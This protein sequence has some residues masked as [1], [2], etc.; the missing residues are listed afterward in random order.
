MPIEKHTKR[1]Y[2]KFGAVYQKGRETP[3]GLPYN[4]FYEVPS[5]L[6]A[7]GK[8]KGKKLL[9]IGCGAGVHTNKY[10]QKDAIVKGIDISKTMIAM[11]KKRHPNLEFKVGSI[12][13][14]PYKNSS[15]DIATSSLMIHYVDDL[16]KAF[17]E[18]SRVLK[19]GG[20]FYFST[21]NP[22]TAARETYEDRRLK[23]RA[24]G[25]VVDKK[26]NKKI[27]LGN[28]GEYIL[29]EKWFTGKRSGEYIAKTSSKWIVKSYVRTVGTY[30]KTL[31]NAGFEVINFID[32]QP[33]LAFK[34]L[35]PDEYQKLRKCPAF[36]IY[37]ARKK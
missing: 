33:T 5:I 29:T 6:K 20:L 31:S 3:G 22:I 19:K 30:I 14:L 8:I 36:S 2:D 13:N 26:R 28:P 17:K 27:F 18:V 1:M 7:I 37:V 11:A 16:K 4:E 21:D 35:D 23:I 34:K 24:V 9:D 32:C 12:T 10:A 15:F 25:Y